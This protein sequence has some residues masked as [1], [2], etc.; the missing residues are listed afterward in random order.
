MVVAEQLDGLPAGSVANARKTKVP[1]AESDGPFAV[2]SA[3]VLFEDDP[4]PF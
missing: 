2:M 1:S 4:L 3:S